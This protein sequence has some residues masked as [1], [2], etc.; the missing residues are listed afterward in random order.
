V[1]APTYSDDE[2]TVPQQSDFGSAPAVANPT[3]PSPALS[4]APSPNPD[5]PAA[6]AARPKPP[7]AAL[8]GLTLLAGLG[9][10]LVAAPFLLGDQDRAAAW[11]TA[12]LVDVGSGAVLTLLALTGLFGYLGA[13]VGWSARYGRN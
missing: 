13:A 6:V 12:T 5:L 9:G 2:P 10:W 11:T 4:P 1:T 3:V 7:V 8:T